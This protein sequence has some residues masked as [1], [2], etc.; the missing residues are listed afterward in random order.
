M[1]TQKINNLLHIIYH[2]LLDALNGKL[3]CIFREEYNN[4][5]AKK[6]NVISI[7]IAE[8]MNK[9]KQKLMELLHKDVE[10]SR[11]TEEERV[12]LEKEKAV[13]EHAWLEAEEDKAWAKKEVED[14]ERIT[15]LLNLQCEIKKCCKNLLSQCNMDLSNLSDY[16]IL[17]LKR[18]LF[19]LMT[20][21]NLI[22][23][24]TSFSKFAPYCDME[25][26]ELHTLRDDT[27]AKLA[28]FAKK[29]EQAIEDGD[30]SE[31]KVKLGLGLRIPY[32]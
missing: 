30:L 1:Q 24:V 12:H 6:F 32:Y 18:D 5:F 13:T 2:C 22:G 9:L 28:A 8:L 4:R 20:E 3:K 23:K 21:F 31:I 15:G 10:T 26:I 7:K 11:K 17:D 29:L 25:M 14:A 19:N 16:Q 27:A